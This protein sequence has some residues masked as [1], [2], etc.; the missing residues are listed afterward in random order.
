MI[1]VEYWNWFE[2]V[3]GEGLVHSEYYPCLADCLILRKYTV[4][5]KVLGF[6][7]PSPG[8]EILP[9]VVLS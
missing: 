7:I 8:R 3:R 6:P 9:A 5:V 2:E 1:A 4:T